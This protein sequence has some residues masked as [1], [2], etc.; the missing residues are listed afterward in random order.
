MKLTWSIFTKVEE[1]KLKSRKPS[2]GIIQVIS[3]SRYLTSQFLI[4]HNI[5]PALTS[6]LKTAKLVNCII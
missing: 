3:V 6:K 1:V 4:K 5:F 2:A